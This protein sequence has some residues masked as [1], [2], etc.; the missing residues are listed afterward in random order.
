MLKKILI[1]LLIAASGVCAGDVDE[2]PG[3]SDLD[4]EPSTIVAGH[5]NVISGDFVDSEVDIVI[6]GPHPFT[7]ERYYSSSN[8][9]DSDFGKGWST[10]LGGTL[11]FHRSTSR[12]NHGKEIEYTVNL[13]NNSGQSCQFIIDTYVPKHKEAQSRKFRI[14]DNYFN[15]SITNTSKGVIG[16]QTNIKNINL[17]VREHKLKKYPHEYHV[18]LPDGVLDTYTRNQG[19]NNDRD[20]TYHLTQQKNPDYTQFSFDYATDFK[21]IRRAKL[22]NWNGTE[23]GALT[24]LH[25]RIPQECKN[26]LKACD[27]REIVY[28]SYPIGEKKHYKLSSIKRNDAP[29]IEYKWK[30]LHKS[31]HNARLIKKLFP[32]NR[33]LGIDYCDGDDYDI[34]KEKIHKRLNH[35]WLYSRVS[36][37][38]APLGTGPEPKQYYRF[39]YHLPDGP[40]GSG[41]TVVYDALNNRSNYFFD[42]NKRLTGL[43]K[44]YKDGKKYTNEWMHWG[45]RNSPEASQLISRNF[46]VSGAPHKTY[47]RVFHYSLKGDI[48]HDILYGNL[49][50]KCLQ[51]LNVDAAGNPQGPNLE[52]LVKS[53]AYSNDKY[54][55]LTISHIGLLKKI[56]SYYPETNL[57]KACYHTAESSGTFLRQ[58]YEYDN[59][60]VAITTITDDGT[61]NDLNDLS[62]VTSRQIERIRT[63]QSY[64]FGMPIEVS[65]FVLDLKTNSEVLVTRK[66]KAFDLYGHLIKEELYDCNNVLCSTQEWSYDAHGNVIREVTANNLIIQ[67]EYDA[68]DNLIHES[69]P[70]PNYQQHFT[71]DFSNRLVR[72]DE[73]HQDGQLCKNFSYDLCGNQIASVDVFGNRTDFEYDEFRRL[74]A[75]I[76]APVAND[77]GVLY[78]PTTRYQYDELSHLTGVTDPEGNT[79]HFENTLYGKPYHIRYPDG[80]EERFEYDL[81]GN[82]VKEIAKNG[83]TTLYTLDVQARVTLKQVFSADGDFLYDTKAEYNTF[84]LLSETDPAGTVTIY[85]YDLFGRKASMAK[86][87][88][89]TRYEYDSLGRL[90]KT[91]VS[92]LS[93]P[94]EGSAKT[95]AYDVLG[96]VVEEK[97]ETLEGKVTSSLKYAYD[98]DGN[99]TLIEQQTDAG[100]SVTQIVYDTH[101][102]PVKTIDALGNVSV[103]RLRLDYFNEHG[104]RVPVM[105]SIDPLGQTSL[106]I[107]DTEGRVVQKIKKNAQGQEVQKTLYRYNHNGKCTR[108]I[109]TVFS[110]DGSTREIVTR[111]EYD[112]L[113]R[114]TAVVQSYGNTNE[115]RTSYTYNRFGQKSA[116]MKSDGVAI[117]Y[118]YDAFG[119]LY[120]MMS[121][122]NSIHYR[123][124]YD[125]NSNPILVSNLV[126]GTATTRKYDQLNQIVYEK[127]AN[128]LEAKTSYTFDG[129]PKEIT[130]P[131]QS[132][133]AFDYDGPLLKSVEKIT[134]EG[135]SQYK[136]T[137]AEYDMNGRLSKAS[138]INNLGEIYY[139]YTLKGEL[140]SIK[141]PYYEEDLHQSYDAM[142]NLLKRAIKDAVGS[143]EENFAYDALY[144]IN[145]ETGHF[146][147]RY[148]HD[149]VYNRCSKNNRSYSVNSLNQLLSDGESSYSYDGCGNLLEI[150]NP[151]SCR[152]F[153]YDALD[154][155]TSLQEGTTRIAY[156]YDDQN[157]CVLRKQYAEGLIT[158]TEKIFYLGQNDVGTVNE[159]G[160]FTHLRILGKGIAAEIGAAIAIELNGIAYAPLH[161]HNG[162]VTCLIGPN[163]QILETYR[164]SAFGEEQIFS[165]TSLNPWR[166]ASKRTD[167]GYVLFGRRFYNPE[168]GRW[169]SPDPLGH[170]AGP[171]LYAYV[172][173]NPL[174]HHDAYGLYGAI[175]SNYSSSTY[176][177]RA[178]NSPIANTL[179]SIGTNALRYASLGGY[180]LYSA[181]ETF[182]RDVV[183]T[184]IKE[185]FARLCHFFANGNTTNYKPSFGPGCNVCQTI[186]TK[187]QPINEGKVKLRFINGVKN[188]EG[189]ALISAIRVSMG[190]GEAETVSIYDSTHGLIDDLLECAMLMCGVRTHATELLIQQI[191]KDIAELGGV[192]S[193]G[194]IK[195][196]AHSQG[197]LTLKNA[198]DGLTPEEKSMLDISTFGGACLINDPDVKRCVNYVSNLDLIPAIANPFRYISARCGSCP[199]VQFLKAESGWIEH[200]FACKTYDLAFER[201]T[202]KTKQRYNIKV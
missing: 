158:K 127:L 195:C 32:E 102:V 174:T 149:S 177:N 129:S 124:T 81:E 125:V 165:E 85:T 144:Q 113:Q 27:G 110:P 17:N 120:E 136:H 168:T 140:E 141:T 1:T 6:P 97:V 175:T 121:S 169:L 108:S 56:Y 137:Y 98:Y 93:N 150:V 184:P 180:Y 53:Y 54:N 134:P 155:I 62:G 185:P 89:L 128:G 71:Y 29:D 189:E 162:N 146:N 2:Q 35:I 190:Y 201:D 4:Q 200:S 24:L 50:G 14:V 96:R 74:K 117:A 41:T 100:L 57:C 65:N 38:E 156:T 67:R 131:D 20:Q 11:E 49:T 66:V 170:D 105:E 101:K 5:V 187:G 159:E 132:L 123:Y 45:P 37:L 118:T 59:C 95:V 16:A 91:I 51:Q 9:T 163:K 61:S 115:K 153:T 77:E 191:R 70:N 75:K 188:S 80:T 76:C 176:A 44:F 198:L 199:N 52:R 47:C 23:L 60:G 183:P 28:I 79:T 202:M 145:N 197:A 88:I 186:E 154:R 21:K 104:Q 64:P 72:V 12:G 148:S 83:L 30:V 151:S 15:K 119:R 19:T 135:I 161:D 73:F 172:S 39:E 114:P 22:H 33:Y 36:R 109:E 34:S 10:N 42:K 112:S 160:N 18:T 122:D 69:G 179:T 133:V 171:N 31:E 152:K 94:T 68:N 138:L 58:F 26:V 147:N 3:I 139:R 111:W 92:S 106:S 84:H 7:F 13:N 90:A 55:L 173:N 142:G 46:G 43:T 99:R 126:D 82:L 157:R 107:Q 78:R 86:A 63:S 182:F 193:G 130:L 25:G 181:A 192:N 87:D 40:E 196:I 48:E 194:V 8:E 166:F 167:H 178:R 164:Y 116:Q 103:T 143:K